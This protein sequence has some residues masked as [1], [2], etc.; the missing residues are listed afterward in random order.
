MCLWLVIG[1]TQPTILTIGHATTHKHK[2]LLNYD[3]TFEF[4]LLFLFLLANG[5]AMKSN[6]KYNEKQPNPFSQTTSSIEAP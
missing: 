1:N 3:Y 4:L 2:G 5:W 6:D